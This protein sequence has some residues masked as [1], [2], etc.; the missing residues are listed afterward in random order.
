MEGET[1]KRNLDDLIVKLTNRLSEPIPYICTF[2]GGTGVW[3]ASSSSQEGPVMTPPSEQLSGQQ[4]REQQPS[5][6]PRE[7]LGEQLSEQPSEQQTGRHVAKQC[8]GF[9]LHT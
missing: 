6:E 8:L 4:P 9:V 1:N 7:Q 5:E 3:T 2:L